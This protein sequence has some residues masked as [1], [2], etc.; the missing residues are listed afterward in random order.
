MGVP[1][2]NG[3]TLLHIAAADPSRAS[4]LRA[5]LSQGYD[6]TIRNRAME[7]PLDVAVRCGNVEAARILREHRAE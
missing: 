4:V 2:K 5:L 3:N 1:D 6:P 7:T